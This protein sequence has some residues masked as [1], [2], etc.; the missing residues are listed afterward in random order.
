VVPKTR[1]N[2]IQEVGCEGGEW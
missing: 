2:K 1:Y